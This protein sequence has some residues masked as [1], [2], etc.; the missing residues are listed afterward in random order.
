MFYN[1]W[2]RDHYVGN[3]FAFATN[4]RAISCT[5]NAPGGFH[6]STIAE[7]GTIYGKLRDVFGNTGGRCVVDSAFCREMHPF[8][9]KSAQ[10][11]QGS[12][13]HA[14][15]VMVVTRIQQ[16]V[17]ALSGVAVLASWSSLSC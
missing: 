6:D 5:L 2:N 10:D 13:H 15:E 3:A 12:A 7:R 9:I 8:S 11:Y 17:K 1:G 4:G 14:A 16:L